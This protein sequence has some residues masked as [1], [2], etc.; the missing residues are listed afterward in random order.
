MI[1]GVLPEPDLEFG[2][3]GRH[4]DPRHGIATHGPLDSGTD[5]APERI[6]VGI[7]GSSPAIEGV[8]NWLGR[9]REPINGK[10]VSYERQRSLFP[11]FPGFNS[12]G[13]F[14][15]VL[16][17][18]EATQRSISQRVFA[19]AEQQSPSA[20]VATLV[21]AYMEEIS[22]LS[23]R[24]SCDVIICA[25]PEMEQLGPHQSRV[26][27]N[28][29]ADFH[30]QL[31]AAALTYPTPLQ[32]I[33]PETWDESTPPPKGFKRQTVQD[34][35]T[36]AWN[37]HTALYYKAGGAP[38]RLVRSYADTT[39]CYL[40]ISFYNALGNEKLHTSVAQLFNERGEGVVVRGGPAAVM[41]DDRQPHLSQDDAR[42]LARAALNAY[43][44][45]HK[46]YP[47][48]LVVHKSSQFRAPERDGIDGAADEF[49]IDDVDLI[50]ISTNDSVRLFRGSEHPPLRGTFAQIA[51]ERLLVY[52]RGS[53]D[54]YG[55]HPGQR[56]PIP[57]MLR[58]IGTHHQ[59]DKIA[60]ET[61]ALTKLNWNHSQ[62]DGHLP[63][64]LHASSKVKALLRRLNPEATIARRY[65]HYM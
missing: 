4:V 16:V 3:G 12:D 64:T 27:P 25:R 52:T 9:A 48:R 2:G 28:A 31:K 5:L 57:L 59:P 29:R 37:L 24:A 40:G 20:C 58:P 62:L 17:F 34:P 45:E 13:A 60:A 18:E 56:I 61:L 26:A 53:V 54:F 35:A 22:W 19:T 41:K 8:R 46:N 21:E 49:N 51:Q 50:W 65:A 39:T 1:G 47:A 44:K 11:N 6:R 10:V 33:R 55:T 23:E 36:R 14:R 42:D 32:V 15:S 43:R 30:D 63:I 38:W 7:V